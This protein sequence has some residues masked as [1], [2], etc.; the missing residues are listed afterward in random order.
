[1]EKVEPTEHELDLFYWLSIRLMA[2]KYAYYVRNENFVSDLNYDMSEKDWFRFGRKL[3]L[4]EE[5]ETSP[6]LDFDWAH[7]MAADAKILGDY[8]LGGCRDNPEYLDLMKR[9]KQD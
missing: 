5:E 7:P 2:M 9:Y 8:Y 6:C 3:G 4:L 1:M